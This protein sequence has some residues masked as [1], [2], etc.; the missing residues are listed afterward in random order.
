MNG[1]V[2]IDCG[3]IRIE[4]NL[5]SFC[6]QSYWAVLN[7]HV[8]WCVQRPTEGCCYGEIR[9]IVVLQV[10]L[11]EKLGYHTLAIFGETCFSYH[12]FTL[13]DFRFVNIVLVIIH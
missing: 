12:T 10:S 4:T 9:N 1:G 5:G 3:L 2:I 6:V 7:M 11:L 8:Y 13:Q